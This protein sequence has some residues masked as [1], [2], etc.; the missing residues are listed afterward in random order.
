M[1]LLH[2]FFLRDTYCFSAVALAPFDE[3]AIASLGSARKKEPTFPLEVSTSPAL[4]YFC[5]SS[6]KTLEP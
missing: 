4:T 2:C 6:K 5:S 3:P 1:V